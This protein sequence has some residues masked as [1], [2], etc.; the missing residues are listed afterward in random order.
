MMPFFF[1]GTVSIVLFYIFC[2]AFR[3]FRY[4]LLHAAFFVALYGAVYFFTENNVGA[5]SLEHEDGV[6]LR[7][8]SNTIGTRSL[9]IF[10]S[11]RSHMGG[12]LSGGK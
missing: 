2:D 3:S 7:Q 8:D 6:S 9:F 12:G 11:S 4:L 5:E 10:Y 1:V